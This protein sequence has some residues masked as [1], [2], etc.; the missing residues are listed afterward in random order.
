MQTGWNRDGVRGI[1]PI[2]REVNDIL[3]QVQAEQFLYFD[4]AT[5]DLPILTTIDSVY[6]YN[7]PSDIWSVG[8]IV[9]KYPLQDFY[10]LYPLSNYGF[11]ENLAIPV[12]DTWIGGK[13]YLR[14]KQI[15][16]WEKSGNNPARI[17]FTVNPGDT[18]DIFCYTG[19]KLPTPITSENIPIGIP[20][21]FH[22]SHFLPAVIKM[23]EGFQTN[24]LSEAREYIGQRIRPQIWEEMNKG[25]QGQSGHV[26]RRGF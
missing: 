25:P 22:T 9:I 14:F 18:S 5:G 20:D 26:K 19:Y 16:T 1:L 10:D 4:P 24:T 7:L 13:R 17:L 12:E 8:D 6:S 15:R 21:R 11:K 23:I 2:V 3:C